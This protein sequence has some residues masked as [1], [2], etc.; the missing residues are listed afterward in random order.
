MMGLTAL[1]LWGMFLSA[2]LAATIL[3]LGSEVVLTALLLG[4]YDPG[5]VLAVATLGNVLGAVVNY[6]MGAWGSQWVISRWFAGSRAEVD[7]AMERFRRWGS[8]SLLLAWV[9]VIGDP[10]TVAAGMVRVGMVRFLVLVTLG[11]GLRY[12]VLAQGVL[13]L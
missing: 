13:A 2:F 7:R 5:P 10:L 8:W 3:P 11:K 4:K 9:P 1:G 6:A 12:W